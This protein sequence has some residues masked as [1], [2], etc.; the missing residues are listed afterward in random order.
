MTITEDPLLALIVRFVVSEDR[1]ERADE[2]FVQ[3]QLATLQAYVDRY[4]AEEKQPRAMQWIEQHAANY[5]REW[6]K[7]VLPRRAAENRCN[8]C[9][10]NSGDR[11]AHCTIH[12]KWLKLLQTYL[13]DEIDSGEYVQNS[14]EL[15]REHKDELRILGC[16]LKTGSC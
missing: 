6:Q 13:N 12:G 8:D 1:N 5:R 4:P 15:L 3:R 9:P 14:L 16:G 2:E 11:A 10:L 7:K